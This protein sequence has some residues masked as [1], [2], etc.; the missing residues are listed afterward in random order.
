M[1]I[2]KCGENTNSKRRELKQHGTTLFPAACYE[3]DLNL[4]PVPWHWHEE[5]EV[6][7]IEQGSVH[8]NV[9]N[10]RL[11]LKQKEGIFINAGV[12]HSVSPFSE[13]G[14]R[15]R[16]IVFHPR[17]V[18]GSLDSV[19]WQKLI[20]PILQDSSFRYLRCNEAVSWQKEVIQCIE[21]AWNSIV[22]DD[23]EYENTVRYV[24]SRMMHILTSNH[25]NR[26]QPV[27]EQEKLLAERMK[28]MLQYIE[29]HFM[30]E[31]SVE[32]IASSSAISHS[33]CLRCFHQVIGTTPMQYVKQ[34]RIEKAAEWLLNTKKTAAAIGADCG[35]L[36]SSYFTKTFREMKGCTPVQYRRTHAK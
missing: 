7:V 25:P 3:D 36:D 4:Q 13:R 14:D 11:H 23:E 22:C 33:V 34:Y 27:S 2:S 26:Q 5:F 19:F 8:I 24:M 6:I 15:L 9:G 28:A 12:L 10:E 1:P 20:Q 30:E 31:L 29:E 18:G 32:A 35:F 21:T 16:S 17:L